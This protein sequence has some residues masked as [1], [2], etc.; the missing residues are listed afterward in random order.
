MIRNMSATG[1]KA[2]DSVGRALFMHAAEPYMVPRSPIGMLLSVEPGVRPEK[3]MA[4]S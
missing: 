4:R 2:T 3:S 1:A